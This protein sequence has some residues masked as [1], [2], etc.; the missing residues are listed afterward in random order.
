MSARLWSSIGFLTATL[1]AGAAG[2]T[3]VGSAGLG[4]FFYTRNAENRGDQSSKTTES[5]LGDRDRA[6]P[7]DEPKDLSLEVSERG[8][9]WEIEHHGNVLSRTAFPALTAA[10]VKEDAKALAAL[11]AEDFNG[12]LLQQPAEVKI[13]SDIV[14][15]VRQSESGQS[16]IIVDR[17]RFV[18]KLLEYRR[19]FKGSVKAKLALMRLRPTV[20]GNLDCPW[21]GTGQLRLWGE[22]EPGQP[23][24]IT[25][26]L[27][28]TVVRPT[29]DAVDKG[30]WMTACAVT[31]SQIATAKRFLL[32]DVTAE[33]GLQKDRLQDNWKIDK[34]DPATGGVYL[35]DYDRDGIMDVLITDRNGY[36]L[37]K[38]L[39]DGKFRDVT[40]EVG[41]PTILPDLSAGSLV[42][43]WVDIDGDGWE[44][45][46][47]GKYIFRNDK[48]KRF[49]NVTAKSN[50]RL[51]PDAGGI[52]VADYDGDGKL[53]LYV[54]RSG[55]G[56]ASSWLTGQS[57][58]G[59]GNQLFHNDG[60]WQ[61]SD[62]T[63]KAN[64]SGGR[65]STFT[66]LWLDANND[67]KPDL[68]VPNEFGNGVLL[69]NQGDGT[70]KEQPLSDQ[71]DDFG[72]MGATCGDINNDGNIDI[73][74]GN[75][76]SKAGSRVIGNLR[77]D[78]YSPDVMAK[79]RT[80]VKGSQLHL[81]QGGKDC[82]RFEQKGNEWQVNDAGWAYGA[83]LVDLDNDGWLDI[84]ATAGF[85]SR[86]RSE[87]DG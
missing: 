29:K 48:G 68:F 84:Y 61:F 86:S 64:A 17:D 10:L 50:F 69:I 41:L 44:D 76:Y 46:I 43:C 79:F 63:A 66:A 54:F 9:L 16:N 37:Y 31:Q 73:Y 12:E 23:G 82:V 20:S 21:E 60:N 28:Y 59:R 57:G 39:G 53:D 72:T 15:V 45:L 22:T 4:I 85:I 70:F 8:Q 40:A 5:N 75:M 65:R 83:A 51:P 25:V 30:A 1:I 74:C 19:L 80:F 26:Y 77:P 2:I 67:G 52:A 81:N 42:A 36:F 47:L 56:K 87:P 18:E 33:R 71:P 38:G 11:F 62:V 58:D 55:K 3:I 32:K 78:A 35:C 14:D 6:A 34:Q 24:E 7:S 27:K 49:A 13:H